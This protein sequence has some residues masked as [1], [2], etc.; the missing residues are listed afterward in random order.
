MRPPSTYVIAA[1]SPD[2]DGLVFQNKGAQVLPP[3]RHRRADNGGLLRFETDACGVPQPSTSRGP[4]LRQSAFIG[5]MDGFDDPSV[6]A[7]QLMGQML[8]EHPELAVMT[9][10]VIKACLDTFPLDDEDIAPES[11]ARWDA[12]PVAPEPTRFAPPAYIA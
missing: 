3:D 9:E 11:I 12:Q 2:D 6:E 10:G 4:M 1:E 5:S 7:L 8:S